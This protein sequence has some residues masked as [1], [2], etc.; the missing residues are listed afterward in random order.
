MFFLKKIL[1]N[2]VTGGK[3]NQFDR[4]PENQL[5]EKIKKNIT[6]IKQQYDV[7]LLSCENYNAELKLFLQEKSNAIKIEVCKE[8][9]VNE[10]FFK[11]SEIVI[12]QVFRANHKDF[13]LSEYFQNPSAFNYLTIEI[14]NVFEKVANH[15]LIK[16]D[17]NNQLLKLVLKSED[18]LSKLYF[19]KSFKTPFIEFKNKFEK[20]LQIKENIINLSYKNWEPENQNIYSNLVILENEISYFEK[21]WEKYPSSY[22]SI[23]IKDQAIYLKSVAYA[24]DLISEFSV[25]KEVEINKLENYQLTI[26]IDLKLGENFNCVLRKY[27]AFGVKYFLQQKKI[28]IGDE[29][30]LGKTVQALAAV[31]HLFQ[32]GMSHALVIVPASLIPN[33]LNECT[34]KTQHSTWA[35]M[36][37]NRKGSISTWLQNGGVGLVSFTT[38]GIDIDDYEKSIPFEKTIII[39][40]EAEYVK[41]PEAKRSIAFQKLIMHVNYALL[42]TGTPLQNNLNEFK[43]LIKYLDPT[44]ANNLSSDPHSFREQVKP[45]YLRRN[46]IDVLHELPEKVEMI[47]WVNLTDD[48]AEIH[49][50]QLQTQHFMQYRYTLTVETKSKKERISE[51]IEEHVLNQDKVLVF[52]FFR[53]V[54]DDLSHSCKFPFI[55]LHGSLSVE[56]R[57]KNLEEFLGKSDVN[58]AFCQIIAAGRGLNIQGANAVI[59]VEPQLNPALEDQAIARCYRMGQRKNVFVHRLICK[60]SIEEKYLEMNHLKRQSFK[61]YALES[62]TKNEYGEATEAELFKAQAQS[63]ETL[64]KRLQ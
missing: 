6:K 34:Q 29:M 31:E 32:S 52:T 59:I 17:I 21:E 35:L 24:E 41:N 38:F 28:L 25:Q 8:I 11:E 36:G 43:Q 18:C 54:I 64:K 50:N 12:N 2:I 5:L 15:L 51:L 3:F 4:S 33:W 48:E 23:N 7:S 61:D 58:V 62:N 53:S 19:I 27:Q 10:N 20:T 49:L 42:L 37:T 40:D 47:E 63:I 26:S 55:S 9:L 14:K 44:L 22:H 13:Y 45:R 30:G 16:A 56:E 57:Q 46:R 39:A 60:D 1:L